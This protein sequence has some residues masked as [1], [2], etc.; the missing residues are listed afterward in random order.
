M[1]EIPEGN[2]RHDLK[3]GGPVGSH[4][5]FGSAGNERFP[6]KNLELNVLDRRSSKDLG[7][8]RSENFIHD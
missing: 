8:R 4:R 2:R 6:L 5:P 1:S 3:A 7:P